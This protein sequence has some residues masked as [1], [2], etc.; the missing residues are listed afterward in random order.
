M[1]FMVLLVII[2][3][4]YLL[5]MIMFEFISWIT[6]RFFFFIIMFSTFIKKSEKEIRIIK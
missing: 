4:E 5:V 3:S 2:N 6:I 1:D